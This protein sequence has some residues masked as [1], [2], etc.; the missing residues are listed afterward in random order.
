MI[1][2]M[3]IIIISEKDQNAPDTADRTD[4]HFLVHLLQDTS[5]QAKG[6]GKQQEMTAIAGEKERLKLINIFLPCA[7][8]IQQ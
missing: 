1:I 7:V 2:I 3:I 4:T 6:K 5:K 8:S